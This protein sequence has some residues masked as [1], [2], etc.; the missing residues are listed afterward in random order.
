[1]SDDTDRPYTH[2]MFRSA[3]AKVK[4]FATASG[5][6]A[7]K[8][9]IILEVTDGYALSDILRQCHD[10][11][12]VG[13]PKAKAKA[14]PSAKPAAKPAPLALPAPLPALPHYGEKP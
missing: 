12:L 8:V 1:V 2:I 7:T 13:Q 10:A 3:E 11:Q 4:S 5:A 14:C 9:T 6:K